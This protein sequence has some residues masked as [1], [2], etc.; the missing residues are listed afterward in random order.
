[1]SPPLGFVKLNVDAAARTNPRDLAAGGLFHNDNGEWLFGF[2]CR[3]GYGHITKDELIAILHG[4]RKVIVESAS[5]QTVRCEASGVHESTYAKPEELSSEHGETHEN[6]EEEI[7]VEEQYTNDSSMETQ[8]DYEHKLEEELPHSKP[9]EEPFG[10]DSED[11]ES[12]VEMLDEVH[13]D[14]LVQAMQK[15]MYALYK[16]HTFDLVDLLKDSLFAVSLVS[17]FMHNLSLHHLEAAKHVLRYIRETTEYEIWY[18]SDVCFNLLGYTDS[19]WAGAVD[20][21]RS[22]SAYVFTLG[23]GYISWCSNK[24]STTT[25]SSSEA[26]YI[27]GSATTCQA[28]WMHRVL[29]DLGQSQTEG[30]PIH[31]DNKATRAMTRNP[32]YHGWTKHIELRHHSIQEIVGKG[33]IV[34]KYCSTNEQVADG[35]TKALSYAKFVKFRSHLRASNFALRG[36]DES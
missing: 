2:T 16:N 6:V 13:K 34:L 1:M 32:I 25:L 3:A 17:R 31:C 26:E 20:D 15:E 4:F 23:S 18:K 27:A 10:R 35:F 9:I 29:E 11:V 19:D 21:R 14:K 24:Q 12:Y 30:T 28:I 33:Q 5:L 22:T 7:E 8:T 36:S